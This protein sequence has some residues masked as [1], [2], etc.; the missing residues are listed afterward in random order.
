[1]CH[2]IDAEEA[3]KNVIAHAQ[4]VVKEHPELKEEVRMLLSLCQC[5]IEDGES[6]EHE[7][8]MCWGEM[9]DLAEDLIKN[10]S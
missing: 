7:I 2:C 6:S 8:E 5:E 1:M 4:E 10:N 3:M 9:D